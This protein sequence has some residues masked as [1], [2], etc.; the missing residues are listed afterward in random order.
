MDNAKPS[1]T[2]APSWATAL[3]MDPD[4][5]WHWFQRTP[6]NTVAQMWT[7][8]GGYAVAGKTDPKGYPD[9]RGTLE[10]KPETT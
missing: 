4:G 8:P 5:T 3:A 9:W 7:T 6:E 1:W 10:L 2:T